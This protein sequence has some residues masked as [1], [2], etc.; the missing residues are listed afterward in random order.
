MPQYQLLLPRDMLSSSA[1]GCQLR[2]S[3]HLSAV[4]REYLLYFPNTALVTC[5]GKPWKW[6]ILRYLYSR[7]AAESSVVMR[8]ILAISASELEGRKSM[9]PE[10]PRWSV[11]C[12]PE[13]GVA[14]YSAALFQFR[15]ELELS[16]KGPQS[17]QKL[18]EIIT[19]FLFMVIYES[20]FGTDW[21]G[22][23]AHLSGAY[24]YLRSF[25]AMA[26]G[27]SQSGVEPS[28][29]SKWLMLF[30]MSAAI[31]VLRAW[32][33]HSANKLAAGTMTRSIPPATSLRANLGITEGMKAF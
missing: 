10:C 27:Q 30:L 1:G 20:Q 13:A 11:K 19:A 2:N 22:I 29:L 12:R 32:N 26:N 16:A 24:A 9:D 28:V 6:A 3:L 15:T 5:F 18:E 17:Q 4:D 23:H 7:L 14:H 31:S 25:G 33:A 8:L 21:S